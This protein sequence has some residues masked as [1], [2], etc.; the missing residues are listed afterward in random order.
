MAHLGWLARLRGRQ[1]EAVTL[2]SQ[3]LALTEAA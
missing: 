3:A 1:D 2:G